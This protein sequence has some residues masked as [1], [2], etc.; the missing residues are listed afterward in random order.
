MGVERD[1]RR[2]AA[3]DRGVRGQGVGADDGVR[4]GVDHV[5]GVDGLGDLRAVEGGPAAVA[6]G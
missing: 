6:Q 3:G 5:D 2:A 4:T 1:L